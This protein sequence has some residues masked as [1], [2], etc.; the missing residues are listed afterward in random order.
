[1]SQVLPSVTAP[2]AQY[3]RDDFLAEVL[4]AYKHLKNKNCVWS[5]VQTEYPV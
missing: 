1:M 3:L 5:T 4:P 2:V